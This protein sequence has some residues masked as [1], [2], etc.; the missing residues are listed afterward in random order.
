MPVKRLFSF[1]TRLRTVERAIRDIAESANRAERQVAALTEA[2]R[3][4]QQQSAAMAS[5]LAGLR[6]TLTSQIAGFRD[7][8]TAAL[9]WLAQDNARSREQLRE[10][11]RQA[12]YHAVFDDPQPLVSVVI[13]TYE[14]TE[15]LLSRSLPSVLGQSY[16]RLQVIVVGDAI[17]ADRAAAIMAVRDPRLQFVNLAYRRAA[18]DRSGEWLVGSVPPRLAGYDIANGS[19]IVDFDDDDRLRPRAVELALALARDKKF[20]VV[21]GPH[22]YHHEDGTV[23][24]IKDFPPRLHRFATQGALFHAGLRFFERSV[25][26]ALFQLPNDWFRI[27]AMLNAGVRFG[28]HDDVALDYFP[29]RRALRE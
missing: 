21:Y 5:Q 6:E 11:R 9:R 12:E 2:S 29:S 19:W 22:A 26:A 14:N 16:E 17:A 13:P 10:L 4:A 28:M 27:E 23:E 3:Q 1:L 25:A 15:T 20:E 24:T 18:P 8:N 7:A